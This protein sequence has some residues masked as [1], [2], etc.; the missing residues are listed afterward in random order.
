MSM[1]KK[2]LREVFEFQE[3][4]PGQQDIMAHLFDGENAAAIFPTGSGNVI[5]DC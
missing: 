3:F 4:K 1:A 5:S 2:A